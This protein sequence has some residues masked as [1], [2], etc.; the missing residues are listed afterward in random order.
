MSTDEPNDGI[1]GFCQLYCNKKGFEHVSLARP[2]ATNF[3]IRLQIEKAIQQCADYVVIGITC[4]DRFDL[5]VDIEQTESLYHLNHIHYT[6]YRAQS[7]KH[8]DQNNVKLISDTFVNILHRIYEKTLLSDQQLSALKEY[9][10]YLHNPSL[11]VQKEYYMISDGLRKL[12]STGIEFLLLPGYMGQFDWSWVKKVWPR[13]KPM[14]YEMPYGTEGWY[15]PP[16]FTQTH[17]PAWAH[18]EFC[19]TLMSLTQDWSADNA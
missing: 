6:N 5:A 8:V 2:G 19:D 10:A 13:S 9:I 3:A 15:N 17:N 14:P 1:I 16:R 12:Q 4:S 18:E 11:T 7:E